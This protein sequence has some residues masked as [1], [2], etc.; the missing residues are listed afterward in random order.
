MQYDGTALWQGIVDFSMERRAYNG[1]QYDTYAG[2]ADNLY[3]ALCTSAGKAPSK[4]CLVDDDGTCVTFAE[5]LEMVDQFADYLHAA[6]GIGKGK[7]VA[8]MLYNSREFCVAFL[9]TMK[10]GG[11]T[12]PLPSKYRQAEILSLLSKSDPDLVICDVQFSA[13]ME[14]VREAGVPVLISDGTAG[15]YG[16]EHILQQAAPR[17][18][19]VDAD[20]HAAD[21]AILMF[22]SGTTSMSKGVVLTNF[23]IM[24]AVET[25][26]LLLGI[27]PEDKCLIPVPIYHV[28]GMIALMSLFLYV[29]GTTYLHRIFHAERVLQCILDNQITFFHASPT[30]FSMLLLQKENY[31]SLPSL[32]EVACGSSNMPKDRI[33]EVHRWL[34]KT[35]FRTVFGMT[36]TSS[37]GTIFPGDAALSPYIGSAGMPVPGTVYRIVDEAGAELEPGQVGEIQLKGSVVL[38]EYYKLKTPALDAEGWLSTGDMGYFTADGYVFF[39]DRKKD[40]INRGGEKICSYDVENELYQLPQVDEAAVVGIPDEI[41]GEVAAAA[42]KLR[43][44]ESVTATQIQAWLRG[45]MAKYKVPTRI[46]FLD[47]LPVTPNGKID[48]RTIRTLFDKEEL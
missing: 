35:K 36:E 43:A 32:R 48:K 12:L 1:L 45:R 34:P 5:F 28:T 14:P 39:M 25:Y 15:R 9:A 23:N 16:Y 20:V 46:L 37:P 10:L 29:G 13:W 3:E 40:M 38:R 30:V 26:R 47:Q 27:T 11:V 6:Q 4:T 33:L 42:I 22:T 21:P 2:L 19:H 8:L 41:Y 17:C 24:H 18:P 7:H 44:G 31:P